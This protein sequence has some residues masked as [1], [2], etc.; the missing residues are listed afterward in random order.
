VAAYAK[1]VLSVIPPAEVM[2]AHTVDEAIWEASLR[3]EVLPQNPWS[4]I[5]H[6]AQNG[7][8]LPHMAISAQDLITVHEG[9]DL[10]IPDRNVLPYRVIR[11]LGIGECA[12]VD[13]VDDTTTGQLF[14]HKIF[15]RYH[16]LNIK[17][18]KEKI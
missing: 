11:S 8:L 18:F 3:G 16:G 5:R 17:K 4:Q 2:R 9:A 14:A 13:T 15:R 10:T 7:E 1:E 12:S 6:F